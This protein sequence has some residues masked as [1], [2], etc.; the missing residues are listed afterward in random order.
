MNVYGRNQANEKKRPYPTTVNPVRTKENKPS[1]TEPNN[2]SL[3]NCHKCPWI[4]NM[5]FSAFEA[6]SGEF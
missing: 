2:V 6:K 1:K 4:I 3:V 5:T